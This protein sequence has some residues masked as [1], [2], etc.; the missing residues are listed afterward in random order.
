MSAAAKH[1]DPILGIDLHIIQPPGPVP[2][3]PIPH[4]HTG[5]VLDP[6]D[7][8]PVV[9]GTVKVGGL[10]R[11]QAGTETM[12]LPKHIPIGGVFVKPP[13]NEGE[14]FMGSS[15][16]CVDGDAFTYLALPVLTCHD[17]GM[18][19]PGRPK[20]SPPKSLM[21]PTTVV[22][23][24]PAAV[25]VGGGPTVSLMALGAKV[26][27]AAL[28][29]GLGKLKAMAKKSGKAKAFAKKLHSKA[30]KLMDK[31]GIPPG[32][33]QKVHK[34]ICSATGHPVDVA[35]GKLFASRV[36]LELPGPIPL[37]LERTWF[38]C[39]T[40]QGPLGWG[41]H[42]S[43]DLALRMG[44]DVVMFRDAEGRHIAFPT[45]AEGESY[46]NR[47]DQLTL[48]R[49]QAGYSLVDAEGRTH[50][51]IRCSGRPKDE[52]L[53]HSIVSRQGHRVVFMYDRRGC[54]ETIVD[55]GGR[56]LNV[57]S[58]DRGRIVAI[59][60]PHPTQ[61]RERVVLVRYRYD[62]CGDLVQVEDALGQSQRFGYANHLMVREVDRRGLAFYFAYDGRDHEARCVRTWGDGGL[63][64][65]KLTYDTLANTTVV[66]N[67]RGDKTTYHHDRTMVH[68]AI[69]ALGH[70][71]TTE[72]DE[73]YRLLVEVN[74]AGERTQFSYDERGNLTKIV[75]ADG[76]TSTYEHDDRDLLV[77]EVNE[78]G[79]EEHWIYDEHGRLVEH[80]D[81]LGL[82]THH[83]YQGPWLTRIR[84]SAGVQIDLEYDRWGNLTG[85]RRPD[86]STRRRIF[87]AL[88]RAVCSIDP[89]GEQQRRTF[90]LLGRAIRIEYC[91]GNVEELEYDAEG[92]LTRHRDSAYEVAMTY[93]G[94]GRLATRT[95]G[96]T[97]VRFQY[98]T[99]EEL[100]AIVNEHGAVFRFTIGPTGAI[101][102]EQ[103]F[104]G[105]IRRFTRDPMG[106]IVRVDRPGGRYTEYERDAIGRVVCLQH[107][108]GLC[109]RYT[110]R[111]DGELLVASNGAT[112]VTFERDA[113]GSILG[114]IQNHGH[115]LSEYDAAGARVRLTSSLGA[116]LEIVRDAMGEVSRL[117]HGRFEVEFERDRAGVELERRLPGGVRSR[118]S[119]DECG[120]PVRH[121]ITSGTT[122][123]RL[124]TYSWDRLDRLMA[125]VDSQGRSSTF[126]YNRFG[127][128]AWTQRPDGAVE[129]RMPDAVG[130][131]FRR[132]D[133]SDRVYAPGGQLLAATTE[134]GTTRY[135]YDDEGNL[136]E[137][138]E[139]DGATWRYAWNGAGML[140]RV[141]RPDGDAVEFEYDALGRRIGKSFRGHTTR[142]LW[143]V[144]QPLHE[145]QDTQQPTTWI[146][147][148]DSYEPLAKFVGDEAL[149]IITD[150]VGMP[151]AM[152]DGAGTRV[153]QAEAGAYGQLREVEGDRH[154]C[155]FRWPGQY[156]D[157][158]TGLY[159]NRFRYYD[160]EA[161]TYLS[162]DMLGL[163]GGF[164]LAAYVADPNT[165]VDALGLHTHGRRK[166]GRFKKP[167]GPEPK[168]P[169]ATH[170]NCKDSKKP[171]VLYAAVDGNDDVVKWGIT[172]EV[173]NPTARYGKDLPPGAVKV[174]PRARGTRAS[175]LKL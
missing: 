26:G 167:P 168:K 77:R 94:R 25:T 93:C 20:G 128:H 3:V 102:Q 160:P 95:Q 135:A 175:M 165:D 155:P 86:A 43:Y 51:F 76:S 98:D 78:I 52:C 152:Y 40:R 27:F 136:V 101:E 64:D 100:V 32:L 156:E 166:D 153:W 24:I 107:S 58:D 63:Y 126:G 72:Y 157:A 56:R 30:N 53:L 132:E 37:R 5:M 134:H 112:T 55:S 164:N 145:W 28:G 1:F 74:E 61:E 106:T 140:T 158:E 31:L 12:M 54:L 13:G 62:D 143:D 33:R 144:N 67:S 171:C 108:D 21:L 162:Q 8:A 75:N 44:E 104:D 141:V 163:D 173:K 92:S 7:Y 154:A 59:E 60:G 87:D 130:N 116:D 159:Y 82:V 96:G 66:E 119:L 70:V 17:V 146:F 9:G 113:A 48:G 79:A 142:W 46:F 65:H 122:V 47:Q 89:T 18:P 139:S 169:P 161:G 137:K 125:I 138:M 133:R 111:P 22:L 110:Y 50:R 114:E 149:S 10:Q 6:M 4:P 83:E 34:A 85:L 45:L 109:E 39:S 172:D 97:T 115:V 81:V 11:A 19:A 174:K 80:R 49:D 117:R 16:V 120:R 35:N 29:K 99:E 57:R 15:T 69:D 147:E 88:G 123:D 71:C 121:E 90:D 131:L 2:P 103:S 14:I 127:S 42:H 36:D 148:A 124:V 170:G 91:S 105:Q 23:A 118:W 41:W 150:H 73:D 38:S 84:D 68:K 129:L 151:V